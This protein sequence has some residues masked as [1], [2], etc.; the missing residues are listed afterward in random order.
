[1]GELEACD[2]K[3]GDSGGPLYKNKKA[4]GIHSS[5]GG[6]I[7]DCDE[8]YQGIRTAQNSMKVDLIF[9]E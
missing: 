3:S 4:Y 1:M 5:T 9:N 7:F 8:F 6:S 2:A